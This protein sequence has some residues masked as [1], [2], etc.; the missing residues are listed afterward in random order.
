MAHVRQE[1]RFQLIR[2]A[3]VLSLLVKIGIQ[4]HNAPVGIFEFAVELR[5]FFLSG[6]QLVQSGKQFAILR[7]D[8]VPRSGRI[9]LSQPCVSRSL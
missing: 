4:R 9:I 7:L 5:Q 1:R 6:T 8:F 2:A 3:Q